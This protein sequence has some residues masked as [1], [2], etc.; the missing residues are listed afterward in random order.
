[1]IRLTD[2]ILA[3]FGLIILLPVFIVLLVLGLLDTGAPLFIQERL[4]R[5]LKPFRLIKFRTMNIGTAQVGTHRAKASDITKLGSTLR[6]YKLDEI[7][8]L[9]NV[10]VGQMSLVGPRPGLPTQIELKKERDKRKI[11]TLRPGITGLGQV[12]EIDM[13]MPRKLSRYDKLMKD[14]MNLCLYFKLLFLT[15]LGKGVGDRI[16]N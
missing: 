1:M 10:L 11:F 12:N 6:K 9:L 15:I 7:P 2:F 8:Q 5:N 13:S 4:G 16:K 3:L 14:N